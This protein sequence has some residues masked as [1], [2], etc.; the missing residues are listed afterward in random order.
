MD[1]EKVISKSAGVLLIFIAL[2]LFFTFFREPISEINNWLLMFCHEGRVTKGAAEEHAVPTVKLEQFKGTTA[3][4]SNTAKAAATS[5][6]KTFTVPLFNLV[7]AE[8]GKIPKGDFCISSWAVLGPVL[9]PNPPERK[10]DF[11]MMNSIDLEL[12]DNEAALD[13]TQAPQGLKW[14]TASTSDPNGVLDL[15]AIIPNTDFAIIYAVAKIE[16]Q[17]DMPGMIIKSGSDDYSKIWVNSEMVSKYN[18]KCRGCRPDS[19]TSDSFTLKKG[20]NTIVFKCV[21]ITGGWELCARITD[22]EGSRLALQ[23]VKKQP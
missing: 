13:G 7:K 11:C 23:K 17:E 4:A 20:P 16:V 3:S 12:I 2:A 21:Q 15:R 6:D 9:I 10:D 14:L 19:D 22:A 5:I 1:M 8:D 18:E